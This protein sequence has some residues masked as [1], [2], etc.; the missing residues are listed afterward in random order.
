MIHYRRV[1][2][3]QDGG[4]S[5]GSWVLGPGGTVVL[6]GTA[7]PRGTATVTASQIAGG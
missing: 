7:V 3:R 1:G 2:I 6:R 4:R 5:Q